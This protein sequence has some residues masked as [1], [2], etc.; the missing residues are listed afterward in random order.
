MTTVRVVRGEARLLKIL[1]V[2]ALLAGGMEAV[3]RWVLFPASKD[4]RR[5]TTYPTR[6][7]TLAAANGVRLAFIGN[8]LTE[9][10]VDPA[11]VRASLKDDFACDASAD[12]FVADG[13]HINTWRWMVEEELWKP[14]LTPD[15]L[16]ITFYEDGLEDGKRL[17]IG[18]LAQFFTD[19]GDWGELFRHD[20]TTLEQ[21]A[22]LVVSSAWATFAARE[23]IK[24]RVFTLLPGYTAYAQRENESTLRARSPH[25]AD[26]TAR[27]ALSRFLGRARANGSEV[28]FVAFPSR[29]R[30]PKAEVPYDVPVEM[31]QMIADAGMSYLDLR[32]MPELTPDCYDD[33]IHLNEAGRRIYSARFARELVPFIR[34]HVPAMRRGAAME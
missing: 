10:G 31:R 33:D 2:L 4:L 14:N 12:M 19:A 23:R 29:P 15:L 17:E 30:D 34:L 3:T 5:F 6:A 22:D 24:E 7:R 11:L 26:G 13:S 21:R 28:L 18:R 1:L 8:S 9:R 16:I 27:D 32:R 20:L 25:V